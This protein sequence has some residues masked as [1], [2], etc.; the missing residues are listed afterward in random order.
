VLAF[1]EVAAEYRAGAGACALFD[2]TT[3]ARLVARGPDA[4]GFLHRILSKEVRSLA[5]GAGN[6]NLL[7]SSKGEGPREIRPLARG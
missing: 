2:E 4:A 1:G 3:R 5:V 6:R 7:L